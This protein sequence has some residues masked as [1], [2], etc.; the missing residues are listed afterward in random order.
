MDMEEL[1]TVRLTLYG[2]AVRMGFTYEEIEDLKVALTEACNHALLQQLDAEPGRALRL[3]FQMRAREL[4]IRLEGEG[5]RLSF[6]EAETSADDLLRLAEEGER[7]LFE[8]DQLGLYMMQA[9]VDEVRVVSA[10]E[11]QQA[12]GGIELLKRLS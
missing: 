9:L 6:G 1:D 11:E 2:V 12:G 10:R 8:I 4:V 7:P 5:C 3:I